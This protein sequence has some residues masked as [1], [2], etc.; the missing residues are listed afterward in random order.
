MSYNVARPTHLYY[1]IVYQLLIYCCRLNDFVSFSLNR[2]RV[3]F[4]CGMRV[5]VVLDITLIRMTPTVLFLF[6]I[7]CYVHGHI[8]TFSSNTYQILLEPSMTMSI[9]VEYIAVY[10]NGDI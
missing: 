5:T 3:T 9:Y 4:F 10:F 8:A 7:Q 6:T 1:D 2:R